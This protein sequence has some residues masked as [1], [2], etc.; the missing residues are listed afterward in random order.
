MTRLPGSPTEKL[1]FLKGLDERT[2]PYLIGDILYF[3]HN[4]DQVKVVDGPGDG[5]RDIHSILSSGEK[6][7]TQCKYHQHYEST[8]S[9]READELV[10]A[11]MKFG[12]KKGLFV[13]TTRISP[14]AKREYLD[15]FPGFEMKFMDGIDIVDAVLSSPI[16][17]SVWVDGDSIILA[18]NSLSLPFIIRNV[19]RDYPIQD[20][21]LST[22]TLKKLSIT[23]EKDYISRESFQPYRKPSKVI[24]SEFGTSISCYKAIVSGAFTLNEIDEILDG[25]SQLIGHTMHQLLDRTNILR[26]G[27]PSLTQVIKREK[28]NNKDCIALS[29]ISPR[30]YIISQSGILVSEKDWILVK[31][32]SNDWHFPGN[33]SSM[34]AQWAGWYSKYFDC[35][36]M[37]R[38]SYPISNESDYFHQLQ[39]DLKIRSLEC[40]LYLIGTIKTC[41]EFLESLEPDRK[42]NLNLPYGIGGKMLAW[43]HP[44]IL[45]DSGAIQ[46]NNGEHEYIVDDEILNFQSTIIIVNNQFEEFSI[47]K[48]SFA[49]ARHIAA[50]E[51]YELLPEVK[52]RSMDSA[53]LVHYFSDLSSPA[54]LEDRDA[55][56][57]WMWDVQASPSEVLHILGNETI[58]FPFHTN[59]FWD[60]KRGSSTNKTFLMTSLTFSIPVH[61]ST[62]D[63]LKQHKEILEQG[64]ETLT[65]RIK[66]LWTDATCSTKYF[67]SK[68]VGFTFNEEGIFDHPFVMLCQDSNTET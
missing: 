30:S 48:I 10:I 8:V 47:T 6:H 17:Y 4:H 65:N 61:I 64:A 60:V 34:G 39:E 28:D 23:F 46:R 9:S 52:Y 12:A 37:L 7:I 20:L 33:L 24:S 49:K 63:F 1:K 51:G 36:L 38:I 41:D 3:Q 2:L 53:D 29:F 62:D 57:V 15:N 16:L 56:F 5:K 18:K 13:T 68:E 66:S 21:A 55:T 25:I 26:V 40:S 35:M 11:L 42:P 31:K 14:Q 50:V 44:K 45:S 22:Q 27:I 19:E 54:N 32:S 67:W 59:L 43:I 58:S